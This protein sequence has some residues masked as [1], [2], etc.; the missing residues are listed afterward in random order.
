MIVPRQIRAA[1][2]L[3]AWSQEELASRADVGTATVKRIERN[4]DDMRGSIASLRKIEAALIG[5]GISFSN[6]KNSVSVT[7]Q[8]SATE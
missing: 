2:A 4:D 7:L 3:L 5:E 6:D 8:L 1:R